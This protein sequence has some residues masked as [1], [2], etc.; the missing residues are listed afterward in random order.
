MY[1]EGKVVII[2]RFLNSQAAEM[3]RVMHGETD[4]KA[5]LTESKMR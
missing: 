4:L 3:E 5:G 1:V 2:W